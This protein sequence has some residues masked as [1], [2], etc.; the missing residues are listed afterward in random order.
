MA[1][2]HFSLF[3]KTL[4]LLLGAL[5]ALLLIGVFYVAVVLGQPQPNEHA[6]TVQA[7]QPLLTA[8]PAQTLT[9]GG[10]LE[11]LMAHF[12]VP[13]LYAQSGGALTLRAGV[14]QDAAFESGFARVATLTYGAELNGQAVE[15]TVQSIYPARALSLIPK[16]DYT[17]AAVAGQSVAG[18]STVRMENASTIRLHAQSETGLYIVTAPKMDSS[19][20][21]A[22]TR[23]LQLTGKDD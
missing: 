6:I 10:E 4:R 13:V 14:S 22:L 5:A 20:L 9:S 17:I 12:P 7:D 8:S 1:K 18:L 23:S 3:R 11:D 15:I 21:A 19:D 16:G 2:G